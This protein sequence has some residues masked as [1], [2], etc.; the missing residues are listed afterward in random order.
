MSENSG[1]G[2]S[3][4]WSIAI[5][6][7]GVLLL[8]TL[9]SVLLIKLVAPLGAVAIG[10]VA[11]GQRLML[12]WSTLSLG[13][14]VATTALVARAWGA[15]EPAQASAC[16][17][18][19]TKAGMIAAGAIT[20]LV[21]VSADLLARFFNFDESAR[22]L[23]SQFF[24]ILSLFAAAQIVLMILSTAARAIGDART[25][26][27]MGIVGNLSG[28]G[29][30]YALTFGQLGLPALGVTGTALGWGCGALI[31]VALYLWLWMSGRLQL[32]FGS[33]DTKPT[34]AVREIVRIATPATLEPLVGQISLMAFVWFVSSH[35]TAAFA[36]YGLGLNLMSV[37]Q[38][39]GYGF[40][41]AASALVGQRIGAGQTDAV[42][43][44]AMAAIRPAALLMGGLGIT[45]A[46]AAGPIARAMVD[47]PDVAALLAQFLVIIGCVQIMEAFDQV[48][49]GAMRGAGDTLYPFRVSLGVAVL[50]RVP[51]AIVIAALGLP[52][53]WLF[54]VLIVEL[55][56]KSLLLWRHFVRRYRH[57]SVQV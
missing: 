4:V 39:I 21:W 32:K 18:F 17:R 30:A 3:S 13:L 22:P 7:I 12:M 25:P 20:L 15:G 50:V 10:I 53:V 23:A 19:T 28:L 9:A 38:V 46:V 2:H 51:L 1:A 40:S 8:S 5:P 52:V 42:A 33:A 56:V 24:R 14:G 35:G 48:L 43:P 55:A 36:A 54:S 26:L 47:D 57:V 16:T 49:A 29:L 44:E 6:T 34:V 27:A 31:A 45:A 11:A 41:I 37:S